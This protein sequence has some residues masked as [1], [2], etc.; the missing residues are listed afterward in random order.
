MRGFQVVTTATRRSPMRKHGSLHR[1]E[2]NPHV[3]LPVS[4]PRWPGVVSRRS[5]YARRWLVSGRQTPVSTRRIPAHEGGVII[6]SSRLTGCLLRCGGSPRPSPPPGALPVGPDLRGVP[7]PAESRVRLGG[8]GLDG[9]DAGRRSAGLRAR[10]GGKDREILRL[11]G[12]STSLHQA[13]GLRASSL[14]LKTSLV[15]RARW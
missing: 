14:F 3:A 5:A 15:R 12:C 6:I 2:T 13:Q 10:R 8:R 9:S 1:F 7:R 11:V 4:P